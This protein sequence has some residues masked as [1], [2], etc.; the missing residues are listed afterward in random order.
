MN[1]T[2]IVPL[3]T[4]PQGPTRRSTGQVSSYVRAAAWAG[5]VLLPTVTSA[6]VTTMAALTHAWVDGDGHTVGSVTVKPNVTVQL[7]AKQ[8]LGYYACGAPNQ[9]DPIGCYAEN[10]FN[11]MVPWDDSTGE[12]TAEV[13]TKHTFGEGAQVGAT[14]EIHIMSDG[15]S[16]GDEPWLLCLLQT[17]EE[18]A[19]NPV[20]P[21]A[22]ALRQDAWPDSGGGCAVIAPGPSPACVFDAPSLTIDHG[23][24]SVGSPNEKS[25]SISVSC[26]IPQSM[27]FELQGGGASIGGGPGITAKIALDHEE[28]PVTKSLMAGS[29]TVVITSTLTVDSGAEA[30]RFTANGVLTAEL[31]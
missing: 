1:A 9:G 31:D 25:A 18:D 4:A 14:A 29:Q 3:P 26:I 10:F 16:S 12:G 8:Y 7:P 28:L 6:A 27:R 17:D 15:T 5:L 20:Y 23:V 11:E 19:G 22:S 30:G 2:A 13:I 24:V 21:S